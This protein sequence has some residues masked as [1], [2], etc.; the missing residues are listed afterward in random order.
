MKPTT[1]RILARLD[2]TPWMTVTDLA[3][4]LRVSP[5][6]VRQALSALGRAVKHIDGTPEGGRP[7]WIW[8]RRGVK[9]V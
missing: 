3:L 7:P 8:A 1:D 2:K 6:Q 4:A 5:Y 9:H